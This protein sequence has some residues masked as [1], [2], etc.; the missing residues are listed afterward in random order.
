MTEVERKYLVSRLPDDLGPADELRQG[1]LAVDE[2]AEVRVRTSDASSTIT[3]KSGQGLVREEIEIPVDPAIAD[4]LLDLAAD[5]MIHKRR[6]RVPLG[7][8]VAEVDRYLGALEGLT[9]VEVEFADETDA[10][11]FAPP[12]WFG[13]ELTGEQGWSNAALA[14]HG[15]PDDRP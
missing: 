14:A 9:V 6:H 4:R 3:V 1:Y 2:R 15:R 10:G 8:H 7:T 11:R 5:R 12:A 13:R